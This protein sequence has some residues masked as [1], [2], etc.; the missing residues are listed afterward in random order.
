MNALVLLS[1][2]SCTAAETGT[3]SAIVTLFADVG[4]LEGGP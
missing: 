3:D 2:S 4:E 1:L